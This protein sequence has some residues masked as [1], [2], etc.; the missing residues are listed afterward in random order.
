MSI[1]ASIQLGRPFPN[2]IVDTTCGQFHLY[3]YQ[4]DSWLLF[5]SHPQDFTPVCT[6]EMATAVDCMEEFEKLNC[7]PI[8]LS[9]DSVTDHKRWSQDV[10]HWS[11]T[12]PT[13]LPFP[14]IED[15]DRQL[16]HQFGMLDEKI[17][18]KHGTPLTCRAIFIVD[19]SKTLRFASLYPFSLGRNFS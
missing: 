9:C 18:D 7:K 16:A 15:V 8:G 5:F 14:M 2:P 4:G 17:M 12:K 3:D 11:K 10:L 6:T 1:L 13:R 19:P